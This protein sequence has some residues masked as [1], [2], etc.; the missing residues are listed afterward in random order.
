MRATEAPIAAIATALVP[1]A[2]AVI[3]LSGADTIERLAPAFS[4]PDSLCRAAGYRA[5]HGSLLNADGT[6]I[7]EVV[8]LVF[9]APRSYTGEEAAEI[10]CHGSPAGV[11]RVMS[12]LYELGFAPAEPGEFTRRAFLNGKLDLT[13]AEAVHEIVEAQTAAAHGMAV[14][15]LRGSVRQ[16]IREIRTPLIRVMAQISI[17]LDY[18]EEETG[19]VETDA[20]L[21]SAASRRARALAGTLDRGRLFQDGAIVAFAGPTNAGKSSLFNALLRQERSIVSDVH[22]TTRDY[23][24]ATLNLDGVPVRLFDTAGL[25][26]TQE[27]IEGEGIRRTREIIA[28]ADLILFVEDAAQLSRKVPDDSITAQ[29]RIMVANK[30]DLLSKPEA[31]QAA[32]RTHPTGDPG[33]STDNSSGGLESRIEV[34]ATDGTGLDALTHEISSRLLQRVGAPDAPVVIDSERQQRLLLRCA[35]ALDHATSSLRN[36]MPA[37][38]V[39]VDLQDAADALGEITGEISSA[40]VLDAMFSGFC[41]G[42]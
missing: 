24:E 7:D 34:S 3:R 14:D 25:R 35:D 40:E 42:K 16:M 20:E 37:D 21:L 41:V 19:L 5:L 22:G 13:R 4:R 8:V 11:R 27:R 10:S 28:G 33:R 1:S 26:E 15:R 17:Q 29:K 30:I 38:A 18:P 39:S 32:T 36:G 31:L 2:L 12:R 9:R 6:A 23:V